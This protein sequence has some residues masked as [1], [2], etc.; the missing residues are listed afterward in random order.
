MLFRSEET[1]RQSLGQVNVRARTDPSIVGW[2][3]LSDHVLLSS[4]INSVSDNPA[5]YSP[6]EFTLSQNY[7]NPFNSET[8]ISFRASVTT[9]LSLRIFNVVGQEVAHLFD[10]VATPGDHHF[11]WNASR[12]SSGVY[13]YQLRG[14]G[15]TRSQKALLLR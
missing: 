2:V 12:L 15:Y 13:F 9:P 5:G 4:E 8:M 7:P 11:T 10:G 6:S 1:F 3:T 14:N